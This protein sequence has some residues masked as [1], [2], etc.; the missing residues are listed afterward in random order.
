MKT[1]AHKTRWT[2]RVADR[3]AAFCITV[4]G[5]GTILAVTGVFLFLA[6]VVFPI[7]RPGHVSPAGHEQ[8]V[9]PF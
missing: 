3:L 7:F 1:R 6:G 5:V 2:V 8:V 9:A 4:G